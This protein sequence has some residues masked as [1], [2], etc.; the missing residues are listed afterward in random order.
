MATGGGSRSYVT[1]LVAGIG[2]G[3]FVALLVVVIVVL[4]LC[5]MAT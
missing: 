3:V 2:G 1:P 4:A 5:I